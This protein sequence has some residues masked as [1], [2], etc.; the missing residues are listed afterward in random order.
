VNNSFNRPPIDP[1]S[2]K[3]AHFEPKQLIQKDKQAIHT[4]MPITPCF[5]IAS[6]SFHPQAAA[7]HPAAKAEW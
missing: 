5:L 2:R 4:R 6:S 7:C 3:T 1:T